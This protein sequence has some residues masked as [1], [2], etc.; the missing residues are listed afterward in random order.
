MSLKQVRV[1]TLVIDL[2]F[3][4]RFQ[5]S[6][7]HVRQLAEALRSGKKLPPIVIDERT[8][9]VVDGVHR[10]NAYLSLYGKKGAIPVD[11]RRYKNDKERLWDAISLNSSHGRPLSPGDQ[12]RCIVLAKKVGITVADTAKVLGITAERVG[13]LH[14]TRVA[15]G[16]RKGKGENEVTLKGTIRHMKG[17]RLT[18]AQVIANDYLGGSEQSFYV[19]Q[20]IIL[21]ENKLLNKKDKNL[22][23]KIEKLK[24]LLDGV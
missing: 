22:M 18:K 20:L 24:M 1:G 21:I 10:T 2:S 9:Q 11:A 5:V 19:M 15:V 7:T 14:A 4:P 3:Y 8:L 12:A 16:P 17:K 23:A 6:M 13:V